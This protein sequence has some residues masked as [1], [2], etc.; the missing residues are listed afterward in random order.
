[1]APFRVLAFGVL[2]T[3]CLVAVG[4][5]CATAPEAPAP[6]PTAA[7][8]LP[9]G[10]E[11]SPAAAVAASRGYPP[12]TRRP[13]KERIHGVE[14]E[15]PYRWLEDGRAPE[16]QAWMAA[17]DDYARSRL[18]AIPGRDAIASRLKEL[19]YV[20]S[21]GAP[22]HRGQRYFYT[23]R[24]AS[25]EKAVVY[26]KQGKSGNEKVLLDPNTW[27]ADGSDSLGSWS[28]SWDGNRVAYRVK[29]N[30]SDEATLHVME[31]KS[32]KKSSIDVIEGTKYGGTSWTPRGDGFYYTWIPS[33][34]SIPVAERPG[35]QEIRFHKIGTDPRTDLVVKEKT[36]DATTFA[37]ASLSR[38]G[39]WLFYSVVRGTRSV[40]VWFR[41]QRNPRKPGPWQELAV[42]RPAVYSAEAWKNAFYVRTNEGAPRWR[43]FRVDPLHPERA[44]WKEIV[45][46]RPDA[47][48][49]SINIVGGHLS[50]GY[51]KDVASL[52]E[53]RTL[54][55]RLVREVALPTVGSASTLFGN[56]D[57]DEAYY[58]FT[59]FTRPTEIYQTSVKSGKTSLWSRVKVPVDT[60]R[61]EVLQE[62]A[63]SRDGTRVPYFMVL[64]RDFKR[65]GN[66]PV[67]LTG[68]GGFRVSMTPGFRSGIFPWLER[69]GV[70]VLANLRGGNEYGEEWHQAGMRR[71]KQN[72]F[73]DFIAVAEQ[74]IKRGYTRP[75][76]LVIQGGSN[77]GLL[78]GAALTQRPELFGAV[79]CAVP[80]I[81]MV[82]FHL[83]GSGKTWVEEYGSAESAEDFPAIA[84][85]SPY[86]KVRPGVKYPPVLVL[87]AD[88]DDRV[89]PMHA[90]K[91]AARL[92]EASAGGPVLLRIERN[93]GHGGADMV[94]SA[95][96]MSADSLA[97][98]LEQ[99][100]APTPVAT[101][102]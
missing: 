46:E 57:E 88:S 40:D 90:R 101:A 18:R 11:S 72:V 94:K 4:S 82:R 64:A 60:E 63:A 93:A 44:A 43:V 58:V 69:G 24:H 1:M 75:G 96:E 2:Q 85:Y 62:F 73:D 17:Q 102:R 22:M 8:A 53:V 87:S 19:L 66:A 33:D 37:G 61:F 38:D 78:V 3:A 59:S 26:W 10:P 54:E 68:Y 16:V 29:K 71:N 23:R 100:A 98:A 13:I 51:L 27:T 34:P 42:G 76:K 56:Q 5:S 84:A 41:D 80:L 89:D 6:G 45:A 49:E 20:D 86:H 67:L 92:Q 30:N 55:G 21:L 7:V 14:I 81:D 39:N 36:G 12:T 74:L 31:V 28:V 9:A 35:Y 83:S 52:V 15:D 65:E 47:T 91:F 70:F 50:L 97:F 32:G 25:K 95:V 99:I 79:L 48:L 77:G